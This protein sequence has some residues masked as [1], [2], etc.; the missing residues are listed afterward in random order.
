MPLR[1]ISLSA[2]VLGTI[3]V[4]HG[5]SSEPT[6]P[7]AVADAPTLQQ[8]ADPEWIAS[9]KKK[10]VRACAYC[11][12]QEGDSGKVRPFRERSD[13][14]PKQIHDV[15]AN[16][17]QSGSNVMPGWKDSIDDELIWKIVAYIRSL[18]GKPR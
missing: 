14:D 5:A 13:W 12:G 8:L 7:A 18:S 3:L 2:V 16:G 6:E 9:G 4:A 11:H 1:I 15:I 10:F 17:R